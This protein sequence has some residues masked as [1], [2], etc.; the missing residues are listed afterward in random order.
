MSSFKIYKAQQVPGIQFP[1]EIFKYLVQ[2][3][4]K[5][6]KSNRFII[7]ISKPDKL[8]IDD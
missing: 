6:K 8:L 1:I 4:K 2:V 3:G 5:Y 7:E